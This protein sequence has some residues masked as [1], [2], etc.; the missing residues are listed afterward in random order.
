MPIW[1]GGSICGIAFQTP[2]RAGK[3]PIAGTTASMVV[4]SEVERNDPSL[5]ALGDAHRRAE[6]GTSIR[7]TVSVYNLKRSLAERV[8]ISKPASEYP[9]RLGFFSGS[10]ND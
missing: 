8:R 6:E 7:N 9:S 3:P 4:S 1:G 10:I 5:R 2:D